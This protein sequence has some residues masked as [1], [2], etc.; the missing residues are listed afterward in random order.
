MAGSPT[1]KNADKLVARAAEIG[2]QNFTWADNPAIFWDLY[3]EQA[4][5]SAP[6]SPKWGRCC[7]PG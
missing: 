1:A 4:I 3:G 6:P 7:S 2:L 5:R